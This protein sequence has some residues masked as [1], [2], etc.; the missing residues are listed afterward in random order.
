MTA[1]SPLVG[2]VRAVQSTWICLEAT[3]EVVG[4]AGYCG[5]VLIVA[6]PVLAADHVVCQPAEFCALTL[7]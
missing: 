5:S 2:D 1:E 6:T 4:V 3:L 7:A